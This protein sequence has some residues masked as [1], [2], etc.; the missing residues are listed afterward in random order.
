[1]TSGV[2]VSTAAGLAREW[3]ARADFLLP[4][5]ADLLSPDV[6]DTAADVVIGNPLYIRYDDLSDELATRYR[7]TW[8]TM[9]GRGDIYVGFIERSLRMLKP[10]GKV[11]FICA[12]R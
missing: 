3:V 4:E 7:R 6:E 2:P 12:D 5:R 1:M 8:P 10:R 9:R 11:G